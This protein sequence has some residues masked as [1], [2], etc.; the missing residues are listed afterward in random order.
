MSR[1][2]RWWTIAL[3]AALWIT[4][5]LW[6]VLHY[7]F[8]G[9]SD[10]GPAPNSW[11]PPTLRVH[12]VI[13]VF[14]VFLLGF[15]TARHVSETWRRP[16]NRISGLTLIAACAVLALS[17]YA[18]YYVTLDSAHVVVAKVHEIVGA[19]AIV[20]ALTHWLSKSRT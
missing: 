13:A 17:G 4:G 6:I 9:Q 8:P 3:L 1:A 10:F 20:F 18:L 2:L 5:V 11:E 19:A 15:L 16:R 12:G 14:A 7:V